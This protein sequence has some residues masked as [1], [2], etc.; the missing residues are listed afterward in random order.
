MPAKMEYTRLRFRVRALGTSFRLFKYDENLEGP[1]QVAP[2]TVLARLL[3]SLA[4]MD[5]Y[6]CRVAEIPHEAESQPPR[7]STAI[8][9]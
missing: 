3:E 1:G 7:F 5:N 4:F 6:D 9:A 8:D 2:L